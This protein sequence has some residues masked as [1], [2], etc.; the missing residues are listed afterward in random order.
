MVELQLPKL[1]ARVRF[2]SLAPCDVSGRCERFSRSMLAWAGQ[3]EGFL[4]SIMA[5]SIVG[6]LLGG[7]LLGVVPSVVIVPLLGLLLV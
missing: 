6:T 3:N 2:P 4:V 1:I 7:L 5:G